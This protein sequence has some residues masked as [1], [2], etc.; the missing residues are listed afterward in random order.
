MEKPKLAETEK[1]ADQV[2]SKF[3]RMLIIMFF[4]PRGVIARKLS[5]H[6]EVNSAHKWDVL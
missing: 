5:W 3:K 2:K 1:K 4:P 6:P